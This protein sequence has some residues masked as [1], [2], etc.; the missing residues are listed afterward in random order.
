MDRLPCYNR[1]MSNKT[2]TRRMLCGKYDS[3]FK[4]DN[5]ARNMVRGR[6]MT[7]MA[8]A[9]SIRGGMWAL[10]YARLQP[11]ETWRPLKNRV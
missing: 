3:Q 10:E 8:Y 2:H 5:P 7:A 11:W 9:C 6:F 1:H 4:L